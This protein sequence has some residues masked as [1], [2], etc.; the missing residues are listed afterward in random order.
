MWYA[1]FNGSLSDYEVNGSNQNN[2]KANNK[3]EL[4]AKCRGLML[5]KYKNPHIE[6]VDISCIKYTLYIKCSLD[7]YKY[8]YDLYD[9]DDLDESEM[10]KLEYAELVK[11]GRL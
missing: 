9:L 11:R 4:I 8:A 7:N 6:K 3:N 5:D 10:D 1:K 2:F